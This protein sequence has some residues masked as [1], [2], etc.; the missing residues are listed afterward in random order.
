MAI[1]I[2]LRLMP[3]I[4]VAIFTLTVFAANHPGD[5]V[6]ERERDDARRLAWATGL[7]KCPDPRGNLPLAACL[8][9]NSPRNPPGLH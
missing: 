6:D 4:C 3:L 2:F 1:R 5:R 8:A 9:G 7:V